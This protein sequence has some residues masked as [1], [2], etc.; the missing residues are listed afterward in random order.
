MIAR[1][2]KAEPVLLSLLG[3]G[4]LWMALFALLN[5][6]GHPLTPQQQTA[7]LGVLTALGGLVGRSQVTAPDTLADIQKVNK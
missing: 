1:F 6:F 3:S 4:G 2:W 7:L 5:A